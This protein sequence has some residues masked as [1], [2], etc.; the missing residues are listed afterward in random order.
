M[1]RLWSGR[2]D[3]PAW[4]MLI[5]AWGLTPWPA[6]R[7]QT[8]IGVISPTGERLFITV[9]VPEFEVAGAGLG[10]PL[11]SDVIQRDL[12]LSGYFKPPDN[13][14]FARETHQLDLA[15]KTI[16]YAEWTRI[17]VAYL[18]VGSY[19]LSGDELK[20]EV[21]TYETGSQNYVF[22][23][24][25]TGYKTAQARRLAHQISDDIFERL[26]TLKGVANTRIAFVRALDAFGKRKQICIMDADGANIRP[27]SE[28][29]SLVATPCWGANGTEIYYTSFEDFN[30]DMCGVILKSG[31]KWWISRRA[32]FNLSPA[33]SEAKKKIALTLTKDGNSEL[34]MINREGKEST[35]LTVNR[36]I[37]SSP[38]WSPD[39]TRLAFTSDRTGSPQIYVMDAAS[40]DTR[41]LTYSGT[42][43]DGA[44]WSPD[45]I[46][47]AYMSRLDG[48]FQV[49]TIR[50]DGSE[51]RQLT[52]GSNNEDPTWAP[53]G[54]VIAFSSDRIGA[55][56][57]YT[58][59]KDGLNVNRLTSGGACISPA[60]SPAQ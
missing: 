27:V 14:T 3:W 47:I 22:G 8:P 56:Q 16:H 42:Y 44:V 10:K 52:S 13:A 19:E 18:V 23:K 39:G 15:Q 50:A 54:E 46:H 20:V 30:P 29:N 4:I 28:G 60:W 51:N 40:L 53:N 37:D 24:R 43:N 17:G 26:T 35:R 36:A 2:A 25:Y 7:A 9:A 1:V 32:G 6:A 31:Y 38:A 21:R 12:T 55:K 57:I 5:M 45:G 34:Y 59:A 48:E 11:F 41:R 58:M 49:M 33:W